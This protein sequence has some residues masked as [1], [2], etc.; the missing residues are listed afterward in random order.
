MTSA[1]HVLRRIRDMYAYRFEPE[2]LRVLADVY[3]RTVLLCAFA[4][5]IMTFA[6]GVW[7]LFDVLKRVE[8]TH[9]I[10][11]ARPSL[12]LDRA[13]LRAALNAFE[14]RAK[15]ADAVAEEF[16]QIPDPSR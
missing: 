13:Q 9:M 6:Y 5:S 11:A 12:P 3:W 16:G 15:R 7:V 4:I 14:E 10:Q 2:R 8:G 1:R